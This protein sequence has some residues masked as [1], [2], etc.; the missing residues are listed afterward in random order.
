ME[1]EI[2]PEMVSSGLMGFVS[3]E[4]VRTSVQY[5][6]FE[7]IE[8]FH[9]TDFCPCSVITNAIFCWYHFD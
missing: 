7:V 3:E 4:L 8:V 1:S 5:Q 9:L 2:D 6:G